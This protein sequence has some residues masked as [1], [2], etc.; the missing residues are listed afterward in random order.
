MN[1]PL[2]GWPDPTSPFH[3]GEQA[4][5]ERLGCR[6]KMEQ[7]GRRFIRRFMPDQHREFFS[8]LPYLIIGSLDHRNRPWASILVGDPGFLASPDAETL[9]IRAVPLRGDPLVRNLSLGSP[10]G[11]LGI[12]LET[13]RRNRLN[14][15]I[16]ALRPD[17]CMVKVSQSFGNCPQYIQARE[18]R[19]VPVQPLQR[20]RARFR[21]EKHLLSPKA[22][23]L[24][25]QAD[26]F[27]IAS[28]SAIPNAVDHAEGVDVSHRGGKPS[29]VKVSTGAR[30]V[31]TWPDFVGNSFFNTLG[32]LTK[33]PY[34]GLL[35]VDFR[36]GSLLLLSG[37]TEII[38]A[39]PEVESFAGA[40]RLVR[41]EVQSGYWLEQSLPL[42]WSDA[43][44]APEI[45][46]TSTWAV[47]DAA[48]A[49][50]DLH[51]TYRT[52]AITR[53]ERE[54]S[55]IK[56]F[57][58]SPTDGK[59]VMPY[60][61]GQFLP[62]E[63]TAVDGG[64]PLRRTYTFSGEPNPHHYR[65]S[66]KRS[67]S[68]TQRSSASHWLHAACEG[69][70][71]RCLGPRGAFTLD[72]DSSRPVILLSA[73]IG[74]TPMIAMLYHLMGGTVS[75]P[76]YPDRQIWFIH[77]VRDGNDHAFG[78]HVRELARNRPNL[79][80]HVQYTRPSSKDR[81]N[82]AFDRA[83]RIDANTLRA[84][85]PPD[86]YDAYVCGPTGFMQSM[87]SDLVSLGL[88]D[89]RIHFE[90]FGGVGLQR[91]SSLLGQ[92]SSEAPIESARLVFS[93]AGQEAD[94]NIRQGTLLDAAEAAGLSPLYHCRTGAC[95][96]CAVRLL[97]GK[98]AYMA[99]P[100]ASMM[101]GEVLI[102]SAIPASKRV[103]LAL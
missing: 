68:T 34:A 16:V 77:C 89:Q 38:W 61:A 30:S 40:E 21:R 99:E 33:N 81:A 22:I 41:L 37:K 84:L 64:P 55:L 25:E 48:R 70:T 2:P 69:D 103:V 20:R 35:F 90:S 100:A 14:G 67:A 28:S 85:L 45:G 102:C 79:H 26:T 11:I 3:D 87:H 8:I 82:G 43:L 97:V 29:F 93:A 62:L 1:S 75:R 4:V 88:K 31:L 56:T 12:Q 9:D 52:F 86:D 19:R 63:L 83:G 101:D 53:I 65:I 44:Y 5:Q 91:T 54:S 10:M 95:G 66:V 94:W 58:F 6:D 72:P 92:R 23:A 13:R 49:A 78:T 15:R 32:N 39:G 17:G 46:R 80:V 47:A 74:V 73:G 98:I 96:T 50:G 27:F 60:R 36:S 57:Y 51:G 42:R 76:R 59:G 7:I 71:V 18:H 24:I